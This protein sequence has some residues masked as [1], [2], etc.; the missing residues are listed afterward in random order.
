[1]TAISEG[2]PS[3]WAEQWAV[4]VAV[5]SMQRRRRVDIVCSDSLDARRRAT[6]DAI[7]ALLDFADDATQRDR[8]KTGRPAKRN[9]GMWDRWRG[10]SV[11]KAYQSLHAARVL[12]TDLLPED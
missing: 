10:T 11:E 8:R 3:L 6:A 4:Q 9:R 5:E 2:F 12:L 7:Y 1:M